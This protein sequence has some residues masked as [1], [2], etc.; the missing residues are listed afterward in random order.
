MFQK[1]PK[2]CLEAFQSGKYSVVKP[3]TFSGKKKITH[4]LW[5]AFCNAV[6]VTN[7]KTRELLQL[8]KQLLLNLCLVVLLDGLVQLSQSSEQPPYPCLVCWD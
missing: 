5:M 4:I 2:A 8:L 1:L 7:L 3:F 6:T